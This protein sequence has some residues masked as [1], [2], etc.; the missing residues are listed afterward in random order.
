MN[1]SIETILNVVSVITTLVLAIVAVCSLKQNEKMRKD[2]IKPNIV[3][4]FKT[5]KVDGLYCLAFK[6]YGSSP[7]IDIRVKVNETY[8]SN[9]SVIHIDEECLSDKLAKLE[10]Y[11]FFLSPG[12]EQI[13]PLGFFSHF[14]KLSEIP[15][16][17]EIS[18]F[19]IWKKKNLF[20]TEMDLKGY[21]VFFLRRDDMDL[22]A[23][24]MQG[25]KKELSSISKY[26]KR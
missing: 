1:I 18:Y 14:D 9:V 21:G 25:I 2:L 3:V 13:I 16:S 17:I 6:N 24:S 22:I 15:L 19:D 20:K 12:Q 11:A 7:A 8:K 26:L 10:K 5:N 23:S 4:S